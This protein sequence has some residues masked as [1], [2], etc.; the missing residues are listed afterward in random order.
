MQ[1]IKELQIFKAA[2]PALIAASAGLLHL[3]PRTHACPLSAL[4]QA[5][6]H[7]HLGMG[8]APALLLLRDHGA[9]LDTFPWRTHCLLEE[10]MS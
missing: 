3:L 4:F 6:G 8:Q 1:K 5:Q 10:L 2:M 7:N 9:D